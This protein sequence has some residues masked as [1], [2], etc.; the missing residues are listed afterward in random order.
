MVLETILGTVFVNLFA[1]TFSKLTRPEWHLSTEN[2]FCL[3]LYSIVNESF[4]S[5]ENT[6]FKSF[7][8]IEI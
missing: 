7:V 8:L 5:L 1:K 2:V 4:E 6:N 3:A